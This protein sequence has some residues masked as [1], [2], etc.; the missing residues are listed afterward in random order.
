MVP[1]WKRLVHISDSYLEETF[2]SIV[3]IDHDRNE[4]I[5]LYNTIRRSAENVIEAQKRF[6]LHPFIW[7]RIFRNLNHRISNVEQ[8]AAEEASIILVG[9]IL[10]HHFP[11]L[12]ELESLWI[13]SERGVS[14]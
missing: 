9:S 11:L 7:K 2:G 12:T 1:E 10:Q 13:S 6:L 5:D 8:L 4:S 3:T 14:L